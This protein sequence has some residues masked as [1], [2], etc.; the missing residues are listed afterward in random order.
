VLSIDAYQLN[1]PLTDDELR[2]RYERDEAAHEAARVVA[3]ENG[4]FAASRIAN[5]GAANGVREGFAAINEYGAPLCLQHTPRDPPTSPTQNAP[6]ADGFR[7][8]ASRARF[9][10]G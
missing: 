7:A 6:P 3:E 10:P 1:R 8:S 2:A 5:A 9:P 4:P